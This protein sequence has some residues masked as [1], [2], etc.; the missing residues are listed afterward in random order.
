MYFRKACNVCLTVFKAE[1]MTDIIYGVHSVRGALESEF[2]KVQNLFLDHLRKKALGSIIDLARASDVPIEFVDRSVLDKQSGRKNH[3]G[4][5]ARVESINSADLE[6]LLKAGESGQRTVL[7]LDSVLDPQNLGAIFRSAGAFGVDFIVLPKDRSAQVTPTVSRIAS[8]AAQFIQ[9]ARV[10][11]LARAVQRLKDAGF[12][13]YALEADGKGYLHEMDLS[14]DV[15]FVLGGEEKG[16]RPLVRKM[17]DE[18]CR[19]PASGAVS[20]LNVASAAACALY[21]RFRQRSQNP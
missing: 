2:V 14:G 8:G 12:W 11:N 20:S 16:L 15:A 3:Q 7:I 18:V 4:V 1:H 19:L 13:I 9:A 5:A 10:V 17:A 21:E 6:T